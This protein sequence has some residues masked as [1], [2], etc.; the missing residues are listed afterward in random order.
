VRIL[1]VDPGSRILGYG[2]VEIAGR[3]CRYV[4]CGVLTGGRDPRMERRLGEI[5][6]G[7][8]EV[9]AE[10]GPAEI[11][12]EDAFSHIN[13]RSA[14]AL[15]QARGAVLAV[16]GMLD[17]TVHSYAPAVVKK[18]VTG[19]G[20]ATKEQMARMVQALVGLRRP[21]SADAADALAVALTH[22]RRGGHW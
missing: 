18:T 12:L 2:V 16:A 17:I 6:R 15:A 5:A 7:L 8:Q 14:L 1:G 19:R 4:E 10:M 20:R 21:P 22:A 11:A 3:D 9:I 13:P